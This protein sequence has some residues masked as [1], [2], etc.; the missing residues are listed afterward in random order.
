VTQRGHQDQADRS[1]S[2]GNKVEGQGE[3]SQNRD[4]DLPPNKVRSIALSR[5]SMFSSLQ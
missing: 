2:G 5:L 4:G 1:G 3:R